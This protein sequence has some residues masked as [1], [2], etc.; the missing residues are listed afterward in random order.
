MA[1]ALVVFEAA[2][3]RLIAPSLALGDPPVVRTNPRLADGEA[4]LDP[5]D[6][7]GGDADRKA[8]PVF[9]VASAHDLGL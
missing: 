7:V 9:V 1:R 4:P 2:R 3:R 5:F 8:E 6:L